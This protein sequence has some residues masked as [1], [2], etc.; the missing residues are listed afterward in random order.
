[1]AA[2]ARVVA[3]EQAPSAEAGKENY[4][5]PCCEAG[6]RKELKV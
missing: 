1:M 6:S 5:G 4:Q 3:W 2:L